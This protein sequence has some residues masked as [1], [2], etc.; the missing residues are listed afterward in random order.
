MNKPPGTSR[1]RGTLPISCADQRERSAGMILGIHEI[2]QRHELTDDEPQRLLDRYLEMRMSSSNYTPTRQ[3]GQDGSDTPLARFMAG[4]SDY[5]VVL[6]LQSCDLPLDVLRF[7]LVDIQ[8]VLQV[9]E[10]P[11]CSV[12]FGLRCEFSRRNKGGSLSAGSW[13]MRRT[14]SAT[15]SSMSRSPGQEPVGRE[16]AAAYPGAAGLRGVTASSSN[17][18]SRD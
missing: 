10:S 13:A 9:K 7:P 4:I 17:A 6:L 8:G 15:V 1:I 5:C 2:V 16:G 11:T 3:F 14:T 18:S 12:E